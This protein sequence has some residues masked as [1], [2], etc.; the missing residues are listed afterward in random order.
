[1][2][3]EYIRYEIPEARR[4]EFVSAYRDAAADL[5]ASKHCLRYEV[6]Q[7]TEEPSSFVVR[8]E[9]DS[10]DGHM[11]GFRKEPQFPPFF[12]KV[13]PFFE[14]IREMRHY[15]VTDVVKA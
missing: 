6:S 4:T 8:I 3:V 2:I 5:R 14:Q 10:L 15:E 12:A 13:K 7:C 11:Q 9:W 1:M